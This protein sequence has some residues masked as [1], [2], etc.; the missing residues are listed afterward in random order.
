MRFNQDCIFTPVSAQTQAFVPAHT[1][2]RG[3]G[4][5]PPMFGAYGQPLPAAGPADGYTQQPPR[6]QQA[7]LPSPTGA[8]GPYQAHSAY[9]PSAA[10]YDEGSRETLAGRKRPHPEPHTP[11]LPRR[12]SPG[13]AS[14]LPHRG[15]G[16]DYA[17]PDNTSLTS[18]VSP[19][20]S[21]ASYSAAPAPPGP[22]PYYAAQ[23]PRRASPQSPYD[24]YEPSRASSSP[25]IQASVTPG[26]SQYYPA[27]PQPAGALQALPPRNDGATPP[28]PTSQPSNRSSMR[29]NDLVTDSGPP[30]NSTD[31]NM[32]NMLNR[33]PM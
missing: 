11:T 24:S 21:A 16:R 29:I 30:R 7:Y 8:P 26:P 14:Q 17:Y 12:K 28:P 19:A 33:R 10:P 18:A 23:P 22:H 15:P 6:Q 25:H 20:S 31:S 5:P 13:S 27:P 4:Q 9:G 2:W 1:V 3:V 32:L